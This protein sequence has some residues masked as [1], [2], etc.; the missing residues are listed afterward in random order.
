MT[1]E[2]FDQNVE[3]TCDMTKQKTRTRTKDK[4]NEKDKKT[5]KGKPFGCC[6]KIFIC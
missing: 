3:K 2:T 4:D 6:F 1:V 5:K